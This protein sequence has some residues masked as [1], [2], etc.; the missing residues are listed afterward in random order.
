MSEPPTSHL[1]LL[2]FLLHTTSLHDPNVMKMAP[3]FDVSEQ[4]VDGGYIRDGASFHAADYHPHDLSISREHQRPRVTG[5]RERLVHSQTSN[6]TFI[7]NLDDLLAVDDL[8]ADRGVFD[9]RPF[10]GRVTGG[11]AH[12]EDFRLLSERWGRLLAMEGAA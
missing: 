11:P 9:A 8:P 1:I 3:F 12:F 10:S 5:D 4:V 6:S 7:G 2:A